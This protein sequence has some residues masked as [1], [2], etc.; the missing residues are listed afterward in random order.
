V[1]CLVFGITVLAL[2]TGARPARAQQPLAAGEWSATVTSPN[3]NPIEVTAEVVIAGDST[4]LTFIHPT[5]GRFPAAELRFDG[6]TLRFS[7]SPGTP[8]TCA[9]LPQP[10]GGYAG[11]CLDGNGRA[12]QVALTPPHS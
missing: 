1:R 11:D 6:D 5:R 4:G 10:G 7:W 2:G 9:L 3:G 8:V 12:G